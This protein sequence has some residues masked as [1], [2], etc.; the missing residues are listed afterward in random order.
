MPPLTRHGAPQGASLPGAVLVVLLALSAGVP[1]CTGSGSR[2]SVAQVDSFNDL[3]AFLPLA[4]DSIV[5]RYRNYDSLAFRTVYRGKLEYVTALIDSLN[6]NLPN[7]LRIDTL[8]INHSF[9]AFGEAARSGGTIVMSA[10][11]FIAFEDRNVLRSVVFHEFGHIVNERLTPEEKEDLA[12]IWRELEGSAL[13]Y[14]FR[15]G[16]YSGNA[17]FGGHPDESPSGPR[18]RLQPLP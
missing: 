13:L 18:L 12:G 3:E 14:L 6:A 2:I 8:A 15:D 4:P 1:G 7:S 9:G 11:Y 16:E 5:N 10:G 17:R